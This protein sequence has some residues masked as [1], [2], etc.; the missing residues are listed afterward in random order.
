M[1]T[2]RFHHF[3]RSLQFWTVVISAAYL[4][5]FAGTAVLLNHAQALHLD[6][7]HISRIW[8][9]LSYQ[10]DTGF[11]VP[12]DTVLRDLNSGMTSGAAGARM[13]DAIVLS[14]L[15]ALALQGV[16]TVARAQEKPSPTIAARAAQ[17]VPVSSALPKV[18]P[19][20]AVRRSPAGRGK[21]LPF[22]RR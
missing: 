13:L 8:L 14:W 2:P 22:A 15:L 12:L 6:Q 5:L 19:Y 7:H 18:A 11:E 16:L 1:N 3:V 20:G 17:R 4:V 21:V 9:P 10:S